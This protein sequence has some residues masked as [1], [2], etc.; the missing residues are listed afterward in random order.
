MKKINLATAKPS[1]GDSG[2]NEH[3]K[4]LTED[5]KKSEL[6]LLQNYNSGISALIET[7]E[8]RMLKNHG[9]IRSQ[10][11]SGYIF[12][13]TQKSLYIYTHGFR[14]DILDDTFDYIT[15]LKAV[16]TRAD[17]VSIIFDDIYNTNVTR[18]VAEVALSK[19]ENVKL[20][21]APENIDNIVKD[22]FKDMLRR[23]SPPY[24]DEN[25]ELH[26]IVGD[27]KA[28]RLEYN[29]TDKLAKVNFNAPEFSMQLIEVFNEIEKISEPFEFE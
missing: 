20:F 12:D 23:E 9:Y 28:Y 24:N 11:S 13:I 2:L 27:Q 16:L 7:G 14:K 18:A 25:S 4:N 17:S 29:M 19:P 10:I 5:V 26:F 6:E 3:L 22:K 8:P 21:K 1:T 15:K